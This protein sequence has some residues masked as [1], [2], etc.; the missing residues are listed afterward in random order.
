[1]TN[2]YIRSNTKVRGIMIDVIMALLPMVVVAFLAYGSVAL[3]IIG[4]SIGSALLSELLF[5]IVLLR[6]KKT[7]FDGS[8]IITGLLLAFI[9]SPNTPLPV[10][11]FGACTAVLFGKIL[12][13][14]IGKNRFNPALVGRELMA[15]FFPAVMGGAAAWVAKYPINV[16]ALH[17]FSFFE[18]DVLN[19]LSDGLIYKTSG[20]LGEYSV[21]AIALGGMYLLI[22]NR[23]SWHIP[24]GLLSTFVL[25]TWLLQGDTPL[26]YSTAGVLLAAVFMATDMPSSPVTSPGKLFY[27]IMIGVSTLIL[28]KTGVKYEYM[29]YSILILNGF[30]EWINSVFHTRAWGVDTNWKLRIENTG[31]LVL[32]ILTV[33]FAVSALYANHLMNYTIYLFIV[34]VVLKYI[35]YYRRYLSNLVS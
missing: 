33:T 9:I 26:K 3:A 19:V 14:G 4:T 15:V 22:R 25:G 17:N 16:P 6:K 35:Y 28:I 31:C 12:W 21:L 7:V 20:A 2:P 10:V 24:L 8:A 29:S 32:A 1:M 23:I 5:S 27:G 18:S 11:A 34:Y 30:T 13:G